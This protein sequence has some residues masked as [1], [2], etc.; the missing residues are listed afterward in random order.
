MGHRTVRG[1]NLSETALALAAL[2]LTFVALQPVLAQA[3]T[4]TRK[5][6]SFRGDSAFAQYATDVDGGF[7]DFMGKPVL[8]DGLSAALANYGKRPAAR[9][10]AKPAATGCMPITWFRPS[11]RV[12]ETGTLTFWEGQVGSAGS[13]TCTVTPTAS[14]VLALP[15][16]GNIPTN[17][18]GGFW[19][20]AGAADQGV[21]TIRV[22]TNTGALAANSVL[23]L[24]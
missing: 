13:G 24:D 2:T 11:E 22:E 14:S 17:S 9:C 6:A 3:R 21:G 15:N 18:A 8:I 19:L 10:A 4:S 12:V 5:L 20:M 23:V 16:W 7:G 1:F